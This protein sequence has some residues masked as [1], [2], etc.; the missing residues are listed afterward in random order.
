MYYILEGKTPIK[1]DDVVLWAQ[2][3]SENYKSRIVNNTNIGDARVSTIFL[4]V[5]HNHYAGGEP[6]LFETM[7]FG[8]EYNRYQRKYSTWDE[9]EKGHHEIC[10]MILE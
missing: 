7:V 3:S 10:A 8:G 5:D 6:V 2:H 4:G 9:A 1:V